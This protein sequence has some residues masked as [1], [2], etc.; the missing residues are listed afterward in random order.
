[1]PTLTTNYS[2]KKPLVNNA[3]D[4]DLWGGQLNE[5]L[6][7]LDT[8]LKAVSDKADTNE[9]DI[10]ALETKVDANLMPPGAVQAYAGEIIPAGWLECDGASVDRTT[11]ADLFAAIGTLY[12]AADGNSFNVPDLRGEFIRGHDAGRGVDP[13]S[14]RAVGSLQDSLVG[15]HTHPTSY[16]GAHLGPGYPGFDGNWDARAT[17][18]TETN[19]G[20]ET[21]PRNVAMKYII[22]T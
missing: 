17:G 14:A 8:E 11:Y 16:V 22:K 20:A 3:T 13:D 15:P 7:T 12:G 2:L 6:D 18:N 4:A 9:A 1:M 21:R 10:S 19:D 5:N